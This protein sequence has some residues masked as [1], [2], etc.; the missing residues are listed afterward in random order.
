MPE[1]D[2]TPLRDRIRDEILR[3]G[4]MPIA[5]YMEICT[6]HPEAGYWQRAATIGTAGDFVTAPEISQ[7]FGE[8]I[9]LWCAVTWQQM[10]SPDP[11]RLIELGP[12]RGTLMR[13]VLRTVQRAVAPF[14]AAAHVNFVELSQPFRAAQAA[15]V[16]GLTASLPR[17]HD[18]LAA[19]PDGPALILANEFLDALPIRQFAF[20]DGAWQERV[21]A[22]GAD[23]TLQ[24]AFRAA[25]V[26]LEPAGA[27]GS[28]IETR[29]GEDAL[30]RTLSGRTG[31][32]AAL[33]IDYGPAEDASGDTLQAMQRHAYVDPLAE[34][35]RADLTAHV[36]FA[37]LARKARAHGLAVDGPITQAE[38]LG[39]LGLA[40]RASRLMA[41]NPAQAAA[42]ELAAQRLVAPT[43]MGSLFKVLCVRSARLPVP[44]PWG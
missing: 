26:T 9:G 25:D 8:L 30:L 3:D 2:G 44:P 10:G 7:V 40:P 28:I 33:L 19:V 41:A 14:H 6:A 37:A 5:R 32:V 22:L 36:H 4:P 38:F 39:A 17:W 21:I 1:S 29:A 31:P 16:A 18:D 42:I 13:D 12:G 43:G 27:D 20:A 11:V 24:F 35:G 15:A 34:P 23:G